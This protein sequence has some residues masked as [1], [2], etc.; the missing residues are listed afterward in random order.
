MRFVSPQVANPHQWDLIVHASTPNPTKLISGVSRSLSNID[1]R[2]LFLNESN[3]D[4]SRTRTS[5]GR[6]LVLKSVLGVRHGK[7]SQIHFRRQGVSRHREPY[8]I[9]SVDPKDTFV[10]QQAGPADAVFYV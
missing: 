1:R 8:R 2:S 9:V 5:R 7:T 10:Y 4:A 3:A 6:K